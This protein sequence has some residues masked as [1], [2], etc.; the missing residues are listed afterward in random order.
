MIT[1]IHGA[2]STLAANPR[3]RRRK[4]RNPGTAPAAAAPRRK[5]TRKPGTV[6]AA[7]K[8]IS[9][10]APAGS[11]KKRS[12]SAGKARKLYT[13]YRS[14]RKTKSGK[15]KYG[16]SLM[17][18]RA[19]KP[20]KAKSGK[21]RSPLFSIYRVG[22]GSKRRYQ[23]RKNPALMIAGVPVIE[24]AIGSVAA[25]AVGH[26]SAQLISKYAPAGLPAFLSDPNTGVIGEV[27]TATLAY[28]GYNKLKSPMIRE[29]SKWAFVGAVFQAISKLSK[30]PIQNAIN[31]VLP[32]GT[33]SVSTKGVY[34]DAYSGQPAVG[35]YLP[36]A[37]TEGAVDGMY[38]RVDDM[39]G[40]GLFQAPSIY[41]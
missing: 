16:L 36:V 28:F 15:K 1:R 3:H 18:Y 4:R 39:S 5:R 22:K 27:A 11:K 2:S 31:S 23:L 35:G 33:A 19:P 26:A 12:S 7:A 32:A 24:M 13:A 6:A 20:P 38:T 9:A 37:G 10:V 34:F 29:V 21:R 30:E 17:K 25:I 41:G 8:A 40:L 14:A